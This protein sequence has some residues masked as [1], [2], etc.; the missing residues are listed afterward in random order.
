MSTIAVRARDT[1]ANGVVITHGTD[2]L[3]ET[4]YLTDLVAGE[5]DRPGPDRR[6]RLD[7]QCGT[8]PTATDRRTCATRSRSSV[9]PRRVGVACSSSSTVRSTRRGGSRRPTRRRST[10]SDR[11]DTVPLGRVGDTGAHFDAPQSRA[12]PLPLDASAVPSWYV[13]RS[14]SSRRT[15]T[16]TPNLIDWHLDR[17]YPGIVIEGGGAGNVNGALVEGIEHARDRGVPVVITSRCLTGVVAPIYGGPGGGHSIASLGVIE[18][19]ELSARK[20]RLA[21]AVGLTLEPRVA[22]RDWFASLTSASGG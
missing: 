14:A 15:A 13:A 6:D 11:L 1:D 8:S 22:L 9:R 18:G 2:T 17:G 5:D 20:A 10:P 7:A 12:W 16:S 21:L 4:A 3:E 19:G